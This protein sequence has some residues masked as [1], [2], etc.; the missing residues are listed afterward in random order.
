M[1]QRVASDQSAVEGFTL[2][3]K[4]YRSMLEHALVGVVGP[5]LAADASSE[6]FAYCWRQWDRVG[7]MEHP[8]GYLWSVGRS[9]GRDLARQNGRAHRPLLPAIVH[10]DL[11]LVEPGLPKA[12]AGLSERQR[13]AVLLIHGFGWTYSEVAEFLDI[14]VSSVQQHAQ[15]GMA[16]LQKRLGGAS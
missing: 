7:A 6:A 3:V 15:R 9:K 12:L 8:A 16:K 2:F 14:S 1:T 13:V 4:R 5:D 11:P 10:S